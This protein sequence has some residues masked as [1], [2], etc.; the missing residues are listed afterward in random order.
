MDM[1]FLRA[2][3]RRESD[4]DWKEMR[5]GRCAVVA[6]MVNKVFMEEGGSSLVIYWFGA[7]CWCVGMDW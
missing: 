2:P 7:S 5:C 6:D 3:W 4:G 1:F